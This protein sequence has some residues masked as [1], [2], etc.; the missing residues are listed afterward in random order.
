MA[1]FNPDDYE[2]VAARL[3]RFKKDWPE[4]RV[5]TRLLSADGEI[6][7]TRWVIHAELY[8]DR[9]ASFP[10]STGLAAEIDGSGGANNTAALE[11]GETSAIGRALANLGYH[12][13]L[14]ASREEMEKVK[15]EEARQADL[16]SWADNILAFE[17]AGEWQKIEQGME[18]AK[19]QSDR[20]K[21]L[22]AQGVLQ[23]RPS[24]QEAQETAQQVLDAEVVTN[25]QG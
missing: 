23:R 5:V 2:D 21:F 15:R 13:D 9:E 20:E 1:R 3:K 8:R 7:A 4:S 25:E 11:N 19:R 6:R 16:Q 12:G 22:Y 18:W 17:K 24:P 14:R 10:D